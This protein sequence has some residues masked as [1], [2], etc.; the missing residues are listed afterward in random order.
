MLFQAI[1]D[2]WSIWRYRWY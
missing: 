2:R 1:I